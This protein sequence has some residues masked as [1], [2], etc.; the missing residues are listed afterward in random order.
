[1]MTTI[2]WEAPASTTTY[3]TTELNTL[4]SG[5]NKLGGTISNDQAAELEMFMSCEL[6]LASIGSAR[7]AG[8]RVDLYLLHEMDGSN[9]SYGTDS[10]DPS[11]ASWVGHFVP[12]EDT[13]A[14]YI[15]IP[16]IE[17]PPFDFKLLVQNNTGQAFASSGNIM[18]Y[19]LYNI[20]A[21]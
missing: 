10:V 18:K 9:F 7:T 1:M 19:A 4:G 5:S 6:Y 21:S 11:P 15:H 16:R 14:V 2:K 8:A 20:E 3:L 12:P 13:T 17:V